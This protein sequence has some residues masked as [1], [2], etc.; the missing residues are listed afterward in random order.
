MLCSCSMR[1]RSIFKDLDRAIDNRALYDERYEQ[2]LQTLRDAY[3]QAPDDS[4][5]WEAAYALANVLYIHN[6]DSCLHY[7][8]SM[9]RLQDGSDR[10]RIITIA[11]LTQ[12]LYKL[13]SLESAARLLDQIDSAAL[14][15]S[16]DHTVIAYCRSAYQVYRQIHQREKFRRVIDLWWQKDSTNSGA[17][18]NHDTFLRERKDYAKAL[19]R[20]KASVMN[21][22]RDSAVYYYYL[23]RLYDYDGQTEN[24]L[25]YYAKSAEYDMYLSVKTYE[26][27]LILSKK[28]FAIGNIQR[29]N[30]YQRITLEDA[31]TSHWTLRYNQIIQSEITVLDAL[32]VQEGQKKQALA[33]AILVTAM[34]LAAAVLFL[35][36]NNRQRNKLAASKA[37]L[38]EVSD[39]KDGFLAHYMETSV[40]YLNKVDEY[41]SELRSTIKTEGLEAIKAKLR[42]PS[43]ASSE[44]EKLLEEFD[45]T[46]LGIF[47]DFVEKVNEHM[48]DGYELRQPSPGEL[49]TELRI[50]ALIKMGIS[51]RQKIA[52]VL[53]MSV[54]TVYSYHSILQ[55]HSLHPDGDFDQIIAEL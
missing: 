32:L 23:G 25:R 53:N 14:S 46:F 12:N 39:I 51:K 54:T 15:R 33:V 18:Y 26:S 13:D 40:D 22:Q 10:Q 7:I 1:E 41:R 27:L 17:I 6:I 49:S 35:L 43:I 45:S 44:F 16:D 8:S 24:A 2:N 5:K 11:C 34:L 29:A 47:P 31:G 21:S 30:R 55:K 3:N 4:L 38:Q 36:I 9:Q 20:M 50:L 48:Q 42:M 52:R 28:L 19:E 37:K